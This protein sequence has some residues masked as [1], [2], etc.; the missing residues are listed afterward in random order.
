MWENTSQ[1]FNP[2]I[3]SQTLNISVGISSPFSWSYT[4]DD[5]DKQ[6]AFFDNISLVL[7]TEANCTQTGINLEF[8]SL[9]VTE[10]STNWGSG[11]FIKYDSWDSNPM[12]ILMTTD[13][14]KLEFD[15]YSEVFGY[16]SDSTHEQSNGPIGQKLPFSTM[17]LSSGSLIITY[18]FHPNI[19]IS[20]MM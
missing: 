16:H 8:D 19:L 20:H 13:A 10:S 4:G 7:K 15:L 1:I 14:E 11:S 17:K 6:V 3:E 2:T 9:A 5:V 18:S 12:Q